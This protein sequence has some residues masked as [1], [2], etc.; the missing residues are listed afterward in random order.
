MKQSK[1]CIYLLSLMIA[2]CFSC[3]SSESD[4][5]TI[6]DSAQDV[7]LKELLKEPAQYKDEIIRI[8]GYIL[9]AE[10]ANS[11]DDVDIFVLSITDEPIYIYQDNQLAFPN[12]KTKIRAAEDGYNSSILKDCYELIRDA[13]KLGTPVYLIGTYKPGEAFHYYPTGIDLYLHQIQLDRHVVNTDYGDK[14]T[15]AYEAPGFLKKTFQG[16]KKVL[17][18]L[19]KLIP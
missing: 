14:S 4:S 19:K 9:G 16:G 2:F 17:K 13:K 7:T 15:W 1:Y 11:S 12:I 3:A 8:K 5:R 6:R 10:F 18:F